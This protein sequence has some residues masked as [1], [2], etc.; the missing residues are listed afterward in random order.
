ME[1][2]GR[3]G[4]EKEGECERR[5]EGRKKKERLRGEVEKANYFNHSLKTI[6]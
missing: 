6:L 4:R 3:G 5:G 2:G 1:V